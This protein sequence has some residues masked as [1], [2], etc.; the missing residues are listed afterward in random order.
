MSLTNYDGIA[1]GS[2]VYFGNISTGMSEFLSKTVQLWTNI[3]WKEFRQLYSCLPEAERER[4]G[5]SVFGTV[6]QYTE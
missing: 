6:L 1:F 5:P 4:I 3:L 2:P